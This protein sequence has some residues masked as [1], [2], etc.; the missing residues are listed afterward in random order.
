VRE[1]ARDLYKGVDKEGGGCERGVHRK[2]E[3]DLERL[4]RE[5]E[6]ERK[7][8]TDGRKDRG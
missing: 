7:T 4:E 8:E 1:R 6:K 3:G 2:I 5:R